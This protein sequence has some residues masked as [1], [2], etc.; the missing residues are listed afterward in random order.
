MSNSKLKKI[1]SIV[2]IIIVIAV[3]ML[4]IGNQRNDINEAMKDMNMLRMENRILLE[5]VEALEISNVLST[6]SEG[7]DL[8]NVEHVH[9]DSTTESVMIRVSLGDYNVRSNLKDVEISIEK[10]IENTIES[11]SSMYE[12]DI[13]SYKFLVA[14]ENSRVLAKYKNDKIEFTF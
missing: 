9:I 3:I 8:L 6:A 13:S 1:L 5:R 10:I 14:A 2:V 11:C 12:K 7:V 4:M